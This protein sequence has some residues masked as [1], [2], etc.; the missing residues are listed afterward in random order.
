MGFKLLMFKKSGTTA[1]WY[2]DNKNISRVRR[3]DPQGV[4]KPE[5]VEIYMTDGAVIHIETTFEK[6]KELMNIDQEHRKMVHSS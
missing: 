4:N 2:F 3:S 1:E 5:M 6:L